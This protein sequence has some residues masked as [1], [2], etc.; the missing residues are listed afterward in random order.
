[1]KFGFHPEAQLEYQQAA[2]FYESHSTGLGIEFTR[3]IEKT[4]RTIIDSPERWRLVKEDVRRCLTHIFPYAVF[5]TIEDKFILIVAV[6]HCSRK[7]DY[8]RERLKKK[9]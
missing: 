1:M 3:E 9:E 2:S 4:I 7:P 8:W 5:Y 6:A